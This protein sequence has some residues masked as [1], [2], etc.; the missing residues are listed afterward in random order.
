MTKTFS[1]IDPDP[2][3]LSRRLEMI[4]LTFN[5]CDRTCV[6][7]ISTLGKHNFKTYWIKIIPKNEDSIEEGYTTEVSESYT[8]NDVEHVRWLWLHLTKNQGWIEK[9]L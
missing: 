5:I 3:S 7:S 2:S 1:L 6:G 9:Q 8:E 4:E